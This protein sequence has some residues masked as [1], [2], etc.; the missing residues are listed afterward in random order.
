LSLA[1]RERPDAVLLDVQMPQLDGLCILQQMRAD[2][3]LA[4][5]PVIILTASTDDDLKLR[6]LKLGATDFLHKPIHSG[7]LLARLRNILMAKTY[8]DHWEN[9]SKRSKPPCGNERLSWKRRVE[10]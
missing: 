4:R 8:Q 2:D 5:T 10:M 9:Y 3:T 1:A 6:A 7:E